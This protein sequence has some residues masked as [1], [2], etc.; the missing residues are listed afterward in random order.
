MTGFKRSSTRIQSSH[1]RTSALTN[2]QKQL[3]K[4]CRNACALEKK[5]E[6]LILLQ[7]RNECERSS[8]FVVHSRKAPEICLFRRRSAD[9][10]FLNL[11][12]SERSGTGNNAVAKARQIPGVAQ[13]LVLAAFT[14]V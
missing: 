7:N 10:S 3:A 4:P 8:T 5:A 12:P 11:H 1:A 9:W 2:H 6:G 13:A 14:L